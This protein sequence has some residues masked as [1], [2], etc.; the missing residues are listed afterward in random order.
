MHLLDQS[1]ALVCVL[2]FPHQPAVQCTIPCVSCFLCPEA[3][4]STWPWNL[5]FFSLPFCSGIFSAGCGGSAQASARI[6]TDVFAR[7][8]VKC[9]GCACWLGIGSN[10]NLFR[11]TS[12][13]V[14][15]QR[16]SAVLELLHDCGPWH[17]AIC[18]V[19]LV[20]AETLLWP[21]IRVLF[22]PADAV[23][24]P[25]PELESYYYCNS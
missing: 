14:V 6:R 22:H 13:T 2:S 17:V 15:M 8:N 23:M 21:S 11:S 18:L 4:S 3:W 5:A 10:L 7:R 9:Q 16:Y 20:V 25:S 19:D 24:I 1:R 12:A